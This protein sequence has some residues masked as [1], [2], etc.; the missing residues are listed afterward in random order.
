[1][2]IEFTVRDETFCCDKYENERK[3]QN[4]IDVITLGI[5]RAKPRL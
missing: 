1:M 4:N 3:W 5:Q 2:G